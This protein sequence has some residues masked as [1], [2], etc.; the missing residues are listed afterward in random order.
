M[1]RQLAPGERL[2][3]EHALEI[4]D[5]FEE[6]VQDVSQGKRGLDWT[7][8]AFER[9]IV[10]CN[11]MEK[12]EALLK[13]LRKVDTF[14]SRNKSVFVKGGTHKLPV[15]MGGR[16]EKW[17]RVLLYVVAEGRSLPSSDDSVSVQV[18]TCKTDRE[19]AAAASKSSVPASG[20][21]TVTGASSLSLIHI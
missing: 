20:R 6:W 3:W 14:Q 2:S 10:L 15:T 18:W 13:E 7:E 11:S 8:K 17:S 21:S 19:V 5:L 12:D 16:N 1:A 9:Q 4:G